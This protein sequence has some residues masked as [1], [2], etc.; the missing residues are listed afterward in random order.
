MWRTVFSSKGLLGPVS[1][2]I[3]R[4][5][6]KGCG[7]HRFELGEVDVLFVDVKL[8]LEKTGFMDELDSGSDD[9]NNRFNNF[10]V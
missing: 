3:K 4:R 9:Q 1:I 8:H 7:P 2:V 10:I 5:R 6:I